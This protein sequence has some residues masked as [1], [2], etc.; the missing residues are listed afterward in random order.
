MSAQ[1]EDLRRKLMTRLD[2][3]T[4]H[5]AAAMRELGEAIQCI[6]QDLV[7]R[8]VASTRFPEDVEEVSCLSVLSGNESD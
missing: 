8:G 3:A 2:V 6:H 7:S 4:T 1:E 5:L